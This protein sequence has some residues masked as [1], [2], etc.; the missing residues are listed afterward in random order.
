MGRTNEHIEQ[1]ERSDYKKLMMTAEQVTRCAAW[2]LYNAF[3]E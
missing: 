3:P 1:V 2:M